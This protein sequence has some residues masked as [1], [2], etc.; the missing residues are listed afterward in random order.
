MY[1][2]FYYYYFFNDG[3]L[4]VCT[5]FID[6]DLH[7]RYMRGDGQKVFKRAE[8]LAATLHRLRSIGHWCCVR[9]EWRLRPQ[10]GT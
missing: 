6:Y 1:L 5:D 4:F 3:M 7:A 8:F 10:P 9:I 2:Q